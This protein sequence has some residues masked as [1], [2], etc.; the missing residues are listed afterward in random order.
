MKIT[1]LIFSFVLILTSC[2]DEQKEEEVSAEVENQEIAS[3][4]LKDEELTEK[5]RNLKSL[6][7]IKEFS[8]STSEKLREIAIAAK[9]DYKRL[10]CLFKCSPSVIKRLIKGKSFPTQMAIDK[11]SESYGFIVTKGNDLDYV[12]DCAEVKWTDKIFGEPDYLKKEDPYILTFN[13]VW[14]T[15][16]NPNQQTHEEAKYSINKL[17]QYELESNENFQKQLLETSKAY[18]EDTLEDFFDQEYGLNGTLRELSE[19]VEKTDDERLEVWQARIKH[20]FS[21]IG[22]MGWVKTEVDTFSSRINRQRKLILENEYNFTINEQIKIKNYYLKPFNVTDE[23]VHKAKNQ[24]ENDA[25]KE[26]AY[27]VADGVAII[28]SAHPVGKA[29]GIVLIVTIVIDVGNEIIFPSKDDTKALLTNAYNDF[30]SN[31]EF[32]YAESY[33]T[34]TQVYYNQLLNL[35]ENRKNEKIK[36]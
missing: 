34:N 32:T 17:K 35:I 4:D 9:G 12:N 20:Y 30:L 27:A 15:V 7:Q 6:L 18:F 14:E 3:E 31:L 28:L 19:Q 21:S 2:G 13:E 16:H 11:I 26:T 23:I 5:E 8:Y 24:S 33:N 29:I 36:I 1:I 10:A 22:Y 25:F